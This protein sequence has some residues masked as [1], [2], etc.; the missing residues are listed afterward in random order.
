[1]K[2]EDVLATLWKWFLRYRATVW[3]RV[4]YLIVLGLLLAQLSIYAFS[5]LACL[6]L[7]LMP[8]TTFIVP[9]SLGERKLRRLAVNAIPVFTIAILVA[10]A[11]S[12]QALLDQEQ[13]SPLH[14]DPTSPSAPGLN[15][16]NG[17]VN[18]YRP[19]GP[20]TFRVKLTTAASAAPANFSVFLNLTVI[21]GLTVSERPSYNMTVDPAN[22]SADTRDGVWYEVQRDLTDSIHGFAFS[23]TDHR[24]NWTIAGPDLGPLTAS[25][26]AYYG[27]F[28]YLF[29]PFGLTDLSVIFLFAIV[30]Y[31]MVVFLWW[32]SI[33]AREMRAK[34]GLRAGPRG[35]QVG[36]Q[37]GGT[38]GAEKRKPEEEAERPKAGKATV[39]TCTNCGAD[40]S[41]ADAKCPKCGATFED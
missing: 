2:V 28:L 37:A 33:R 1:V 9:Y 30:V 32:Y 40:V 3:F 20:Y 14:N 27:L 29:S 15:L 17:T 22:A 26:W 19:P 36:G 10:A 13:A 25:G 16:T 4:T 38:T 35:G 24:G 8:I 41:E 21:R 6:I 18:P 23:V 34:Y 5:G 11:M 31:Y 39:F 7:L 12:T